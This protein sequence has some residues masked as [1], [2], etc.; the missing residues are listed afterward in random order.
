MKVG[1]EV[2]GR[3]GWEARVGNPVGKGVGMEVG[4]QVGMVLGGQGGRPG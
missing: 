1:M 3:V 2:E 4:G